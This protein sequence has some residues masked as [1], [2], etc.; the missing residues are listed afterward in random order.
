MRTGSFYIMLAGTSL[1]VVPFITGRKPSTNDRI[2]SRKA[3]PEIWTLND[4]EEFEVWFKN[5]KKELEVE[6]R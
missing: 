4:F 2:Y 1:S 5:H 6:S 3:S